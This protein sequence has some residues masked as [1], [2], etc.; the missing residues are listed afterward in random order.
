MSDDCIFCQIVQ[1][2]IPCGKIYE[3]QRILA[4]LDIGPL[5]EGHCLIIPK[6]HYVRLEDCP[7]DVAAALTQKIPHLAPAIIKAA[8]AQGYNVL[9]NNG[10]CA[11]QLVEHVHFHII[12]RNPGDG[13]F[14]QWPAGK[15]PP[16]R[17]EELTEKIKSLL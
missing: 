13:V 7:E 16:G 2:K 11:G 14:S 15:Y 17:I 5:S 9:N 6:E 4:F 1:G 8:G 12:P 10:S 3:D